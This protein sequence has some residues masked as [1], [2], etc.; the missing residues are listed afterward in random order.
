MTESKPYVRDE[1]A[2]VVANISYRNE[3]INKLAFLAGNIAGEMHASN[4][5]QIIERDNL[6]AVQQGIMAIAE[7]AKSSL[8]EIEGVLLERSKSHAPE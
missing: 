5:Y 8:E 2:D 3:D 7:K 1:L 4:D 6:L